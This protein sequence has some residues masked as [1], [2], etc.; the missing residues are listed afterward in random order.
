MNKRI[1]LGDIAYWAFR[2]AVW[3][4]DFVWGTDLHSCEV[5]AARRKRWNRAASAPAGVVILLVTILTGLLL[6]GK[7]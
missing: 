1:G 5:C 6:W 4:I 7:C 3:T 2:P